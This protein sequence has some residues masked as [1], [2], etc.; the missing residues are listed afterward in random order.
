MDPRLLK[1]YNREL[2]FLREMG[3]EFAREFPKI[4][5]RLGMD[6]LE[7][8]DPYVE[9]LLEGVGLLTARIQLRMDAEFPN[10]T[11]HLL[12]MA[13]PHYL[14]PNPSMAVVRF[15]PD[16][17]EGSLAGGFVLPRATVLRSI[18]GKGEQTAC[19]YRT[20]HEVILWPISLEAAHYFS[21]NEAM[22]DFP[23]V[24]GV[25]AG[26]RFRLKTTAGL[27]FDKLALDT[28][29]LYLSGQDQT[30]FRLLEQLLGST[31]AVVVRPAVH[32]EG[33]QTV[34]DATR[35]RRMGYDDAQSLLPVTRRS[36]QGY[37]LLDEYFAFP[38]RFLFAEVTGLKE[39]VHRCP[40]TELELMVLF[41]RSDRLLENLVNVEDFALFCTPAI[42]LFP[43]RADRIHLS[44]ETEELHVV[45]DR[46]RP[47][48]FEVY[49]VTRA[50][51]YGAAGD[52]GREFLPFYSVNEH[53][54][55]DATQTF[56]TARRV[57]RLL[58]SK[59]Q[60]EGARS[61]Y[62]GS[63][64]F[65]SLVDGRGGPFGADLKQLGVETLCTNRDLP[66]HMPIGRANTDMTLEASAPVL[67][68]RVLSGP[69]KPKSSA[70]LLTS[71]LGWRLIN[72]LSLNYLSLTDT[73]ETEGAAALREL[74]TLYADIGEVHLT[75]Q[76]EGVRSVSSRP[77]VRRMPISG[78]I[79]YGRGLEV[80]L[81]FDE[82]AFEGSGVF[83][84]ASVL[85]EFF[86]RYTS[87][88]SFTETVMRTLE[89]G[90]IARWPLRIGRR[91]RL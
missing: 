5:G 27:T 77:I 78:P 24:P 76:I 3:A 72:H 50:V 57:P 66:L 91:H 71:E 32:A 25:R 86:A 34:L 58:S 17:T 62:I 55:A 70:T 20:A 82:S 29:P 73:N 54:Q 49:G 74:L 40:G 42:N 87:I 21:R 37:R 8:A 26:L 31:V 79:M 46:T 88:N 47:L 68:V 14:A 39:A 90:E 6:G 43:K 63:E 12:E 85:E 23:N 61:S 89:R 52:S 22:L 60:R 4:A 44:E 65:L 7:V 9:R 11:Q 15:Q 13:Y 28:L 83:L 2:L 19:E 1:Y 69:S 35:I 18:R 75:K 51:G 38:D 33:R 30:R 10:F 67:A 80:S 84:L 81:L 45:P 56:Y 64:V 48:D 41:S 59:Q 36:F 53:T 16:L